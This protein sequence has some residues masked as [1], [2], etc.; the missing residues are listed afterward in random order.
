MQVRTRT[1]GF[2]RGSHDRQDER[3]RSCL[4]LHHHCVLVLNASQR[5]NP[6]DK[7]CYT[8]Q[9]SVHWSECVLSWSLCLP[10]DHKN[11]AVP[12]MKLKEF[13]VGCE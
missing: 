1:D 9:L 5:Y 2:D 11:E 7:L 3:S 8:G 6:P 4:T 10:C 13:S 12:W